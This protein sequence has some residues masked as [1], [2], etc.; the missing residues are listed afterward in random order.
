MLLI[1]EGEFE[2]ILPAHVRRFWGIRGELWSF[3]WQISME[4]LRT[5]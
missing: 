5:V 1:K 2:V 3:S 4:A